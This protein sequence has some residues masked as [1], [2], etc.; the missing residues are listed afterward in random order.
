MTEF[1]RTRAAIESGLR[2]RLH[3][4]AQLYISRAG[5]VLIDE[6]FGE[7]REGVPMQRE[8]ITLWFSAGKPLTAAAIGRLVERGSLTWDT[9][10][11]QVIPEFAQHGKETVT[12][13]HLL[14][15]TAG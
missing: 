1:I 13:R 9:P 7:A 10:V 2:E 8:S 5:Q 12:L 3:L 14:T 11:A 6:A 4:G 15:H